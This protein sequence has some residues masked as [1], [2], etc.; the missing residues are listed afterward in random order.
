VKIN[1]Q[2]HWSE[3]WKQGY[4]TSLPQDFSI[5]YNGKIA[6]FWRKQFKSINMNDSI[7]DICT[8]NGAIALLCQGFLTNENIKA[9]VYG[10]D[11][12]ENFQKSVINNFPEQ[13]TNSN[14]ITF[15]NNTPVEN[16]PFEDGQFNI[17]TSQFGFEYCDWSKGAAEVARVL[18]AG[19]RFA[20]ITHNPESSII[21]TMSQERNEHEFI[22]SLDFDSLFNE[23]YENKF[24]YTSFRRKIK[25]INK[26]ILSYQEIKKSMLLENFLNM[27]SS[28]MASTEKHLI[29]YK[30][31][32]FNFIKQNKQAYSRLL[33]L[34]DANNALTNL[35][36]FVGVLEYAGLGCTK[37]GTIELADDIKVGNYYIFIK[38]HD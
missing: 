3:Y 8:G 24:A 10:I 14:K 21:A 9:K 7:L 26:S 6:D 31:Q 1:Q 25:K 18:Q 15:I 12:A 19:G 27:L 30:E 16:L 32:I 37:S 11:L 38:Q 2:A 17:V 22:E 13:K 34:I 5:N 4:I 28:I 36:Q 33:D 20:L 23:Y 35:E 29:T